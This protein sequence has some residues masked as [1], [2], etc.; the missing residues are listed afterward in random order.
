[1]GRSGL[2]GLV[3]P[4]REDPGRGMQ[5]GCQSP[6]IKPSRPRQ[7]RSGQ[8]R[9]GT[10]PKVWG[11]E[12]TNPVCSA[13]P[14]LISPYLH[15]WGPGSNQVLRAPELRQPAGGQ[16]PETQAS[17][18]GTGPCTPG[19]P[20][21]ARSLEAH[22]PIGFLHIPRFGKAPARPDSPSHFCPSRGLQRVRRCPF[23]LASDTKRETWA[24]HHPGSHS[25]P[26]VLFL[27]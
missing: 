1:M 11:L 5:A 2:Q 25:D 10:E 17:T 3:S 15:H 4:W 26:P 21:V 14:Q 8:A 20:R 23:G 19:A 13:G 9:P 7:S 24:V 16:G 22:F 6:L 12:L 18:T 27:L